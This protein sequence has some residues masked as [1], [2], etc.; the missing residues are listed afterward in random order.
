MFRNY[1]TVC[2]YFDLLLIRMLFDQPLD[3]FTSITF[4]SVFAMVVPPEVDFSKYFVRCC[5]DQHGTTQALRFWW[6]G[7]YFIINERLFNKDECFSFS[8]ITSSSCVITNKTKICFLNCTSEVLLIQD[9]I[10]LSAFLA[11]L[12]CEVS[13]SVLLEKYMFREA[14]RSKLVTNSRIWNNF[15]QVQNS[16]SRFGSSVW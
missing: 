8:R 7:R 4:R 1:T 5:Y 11:A 12:Y 15:A 14:I 6:I 13:L 3:I 10:K 9:G 2:S 16:F